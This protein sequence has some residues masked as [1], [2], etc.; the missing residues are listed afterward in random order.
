M[1]RELQ[2]LN[3]YEGKKQFL[4]ESGNSDFGVQKRISIHHN[5]KIIRL[6]SVDFDSLLDQAIFFI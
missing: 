5:K 2:Q 4:Q 6:V 3:I 1:K